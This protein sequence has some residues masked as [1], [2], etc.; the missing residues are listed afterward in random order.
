MKW[1]E[2]VVLYRSEEVHTEF[3]LDNPDEKYSMEGQGVDG[4]AIL[5]WIFD[6]CDRVALNNA[7]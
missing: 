3:W 4:R 1:V 5:K 6:I 7:K 2:H